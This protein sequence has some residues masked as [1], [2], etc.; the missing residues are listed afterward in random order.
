VISTSIDSSRPWIVKDHDRPASLEIRRLKRSLVIPWSQFLYAEGS[1]DEICLSF[2][3]HEV[4][5]KGAGLGALLG[6]LSNQRV[7]IIQE[8]ARPDRFITDPGPR[9]ASISVRKM[10]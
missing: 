2:A 7:S 4:V 6:D 9:I 10:E 5:V 8:P 3:T 1:D